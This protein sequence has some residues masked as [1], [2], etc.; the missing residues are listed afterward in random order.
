MTYYIIDI[1]TS[2]CKK[3]FV[4]NM[5]LRHITPVDAKRSEYCYTEQPL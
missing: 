2:R 1:E 4:E 3:Q 5:Y